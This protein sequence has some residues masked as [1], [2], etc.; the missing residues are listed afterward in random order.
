LGDTGSGLA[1]HENPENQERK[2]NLKD[3][4]LSGNAITVISV[5]VGD[6]KKKVGRPERKWGRRTGKTV[7]RSERRKGRLELQH[8]RKKMKFQIEKKYQ[9][10]G[11]T[12][13]SDKERDEKEEGKKGEKEYCRAGPPR[14]VHMWQVGLNSPKDVVYTKRKNKTLVRWG[15]LPAFP[16]VQLLKTA[17]TKFKH[18]IPQ[19]LGG[20][21][22]VE[23]RKKKSR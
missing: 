23:T 6:Q 1:P 11:G 5:L 8:E 18:R 16:A 19:R 3:G 20:R 12:A 15:P 21:R 10:N 14:G 9:A 7:S 22:R 4:N 13:E 17:G 2:E